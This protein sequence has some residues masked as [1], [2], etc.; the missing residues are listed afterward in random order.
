MAYDNAKLRTSTLGTKFGKR[1]KAGFRKQTDIYTV[2]VVLV[3]DAAIGPRIVN[4]S[5]M[6]WNFAPHGSFRTVLFDE[7]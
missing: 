6:P 5:N 2:I 4:K 3:P 7:S 1:F